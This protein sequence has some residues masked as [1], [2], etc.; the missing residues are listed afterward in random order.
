[1]I[2]CR[3]RLSSHLI[4]VVHAQINGPRTVTHLR[5]P[6]RSGARTRTAGDRRRPMITRPRTHNVLPVAR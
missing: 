2:Q 3:E 4:T 1:M 6:G 5:L